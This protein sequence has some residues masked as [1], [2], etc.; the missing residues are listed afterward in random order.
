MPLR[1]HHAAIP[2]IARQRNETG[3]LIERLGGDHKVDFPVCSHLRDLWWG[4]LLHNQRHVGISCH[5]RFYHT[6][7]HV[8]SLRV[9]GRNRQ[10]AGGLV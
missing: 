7:Q 10:G 4:A 9:S 8:T 1:H 3:K 5:E 2:S 6:G